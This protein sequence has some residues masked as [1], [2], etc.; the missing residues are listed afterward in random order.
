MTSTG[1]SYDSQLALLRNFGIQ[2]PVGTPQINDV[3]TALLQNIAEF[4]QLHGN[5]L[6]HFANQM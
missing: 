3:N 4:T 6:E 5:S 1:W 2:V